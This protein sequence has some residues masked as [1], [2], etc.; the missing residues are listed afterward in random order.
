MS[1][2]LA[3]TTCFAIAVLHTF[4]AKKL[5]PKFDLELVFGVWA[6]VFLIFYSVSEGLLDTL[7]YVDSLSFTEPVFVL[8]VMAVAATQPV[9]DTTTYLIDRLS[10]WIPL[11][12]SVSFYMVALVLGPLLGSLI[13]EPAAMTVTALVLFKRYFQA[14]VSLKF[15]YFTIGLLFVNVSVGGTLTTFAAPPVLMVAGTW[16]WDANFM[17]ENFGWKAAISCLISAGATA[18]FFKKEF[19]KVKADR[20]ASKL[21]TEPWIAAVHWL[22]LA[23]V[24]V[25]HQKVPIFLAAFAAFFVFHHFFSRKDKIDFYHPILVCIFLAGLVVLGKPQRWWLE[26]LLVS[27]SPGQLFLGATALTAVTDNA[28]LTYLGAQVP[29]L[30]DL[31]KYALV[32][33]AVAGGGLTVIANAPNPVGYG[34]LSPAFG[35]NGIS[36][37]WLFLGALPATICAS[38][39]LWF[40]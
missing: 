12:N 28:A 32:A 3:A 36:P 15:K 5:H 10:R 24:V 19:K 29:N 16:N 38:V 26:P 25:F 1:I 31:A 13:T 11:S 21:E 27:L 7:S 14:D 39:C 20:A 23:A 2:E 6:A 33:G 18:A 8:V 9:L 35:K 30:S 4:L 22:A 37:L 40:F 34:I 17:L